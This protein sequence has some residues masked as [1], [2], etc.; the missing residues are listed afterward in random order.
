MN[1]KFPGFLFSVEGI[2]GSGKSTFVKNLH[3]RLASHFEVVLTR[4]PGGSELGK[5]IRTILQNQPTQMTAK[6]QFLLF[7]SDR[8]QH[9]HEKIIP[10][11]KAGKIII[12][13]RMAD[14]SLVYQ[15][16]LQGLD[17]NTLKSINRWC[18]E[19]IE[20]HATFYL[21]ID[22]KSALDRMYSREQEITEFEKQI[23]ASK[24]ILS[25]GFDQ[26]FESK[27]NV[28]TLDATLSPEELVD[29]AY[30]IIKSICLT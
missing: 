18:M 3:E 8:A 19:T 16:I 17:L 24:E 15:G 14:S 29:Q 26:I 9:F 4:E 7:A 23:I 6:A 22:A 5:Q 21:K 28:Y 13:D 1:S 10:A 20:P 27:D 11:L 25:N 2:D 12:S 30:K